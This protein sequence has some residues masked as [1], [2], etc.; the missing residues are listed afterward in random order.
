MGIPIDHHR[1]QQ[2]QHV[3]TWAIAS[4][5]VHAWLPYITSPLETIQNLGGYAAASS[6][7]GVQVY[8]TFPCGLRRSPND[9]SIWQRSARTALD[10]RAIWP[11][12]AH[13]P[14]SWK[15]C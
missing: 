7:V 6:C 3:A 5:P 14:L 4:L 15:W 13:Q 8:S 2:Q 9:M 1:R 11:N 12:S 10:R